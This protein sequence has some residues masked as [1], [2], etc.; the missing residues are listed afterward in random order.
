MKTFSSRAVDPG[1][2]FFVQPPTWRSSSGPNLLV[3]IKPER[4]ALMRLFDGET[5]PR[6]A[7]L[8]ISL[9]FLVPF[10]VSLSSAALADAQRNRSE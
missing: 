10:L 1:A 5:L 3:L 8:R 4:P 6:I 7:M 9:T 2:M